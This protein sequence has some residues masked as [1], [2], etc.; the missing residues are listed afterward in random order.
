[1][2][3]LL[4]CILALGA[5]TGCASQRSSADAPAPRQCYVE[6]GY[7]DSTNGCSIRAGYPDCYLVCPHEGTRKHL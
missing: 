2:A 3:R 6:S 7:L 1:M 4:A 5:M